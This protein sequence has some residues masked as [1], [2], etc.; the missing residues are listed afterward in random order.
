MVSVAIIVTHRKG[1]RENQSRSCFWLAYDFHFPRP[2]SRS[3][4]QSN[5]RHKITGTL[6]TREMWS[7][8]F[9]LLA[10]WRARTR[11]SPPRP[12]AEWI[13]V[14]GLIQ[15]WSLMSR[16]GQICGRARLRATAAIVALAFPTI[17]RAPA[18]DRLT[19]YGCWKIDSFSNRFSAIRGTEK[20]RRCASTV[21]IG[22]RLFIGHCIGCVCGLWLR[23]F[24]GGKCRF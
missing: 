24:V 10:R 16:L 14:I 5:S 20:T 12:R 17:F 7:G 23:F 11:V 13:I 6:S 18:R 22:C 9:A 21:L 4:G 2:A 1:N 15:L 8:D 3:N 19:T